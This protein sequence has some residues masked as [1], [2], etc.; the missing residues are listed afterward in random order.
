MPNRTDLEVALVNAKRSFRLCQLDVR[1]PQFFG[2]S[3][4][5][6]NNAAGFHFGAAVYSTACNLRIV[7]LA[8][9]GQTDAVS[10]RRQLAAVTATS[11]AAGFARR[12]WITPRN[13][14]SFGHGAGRGL[15]RRTRVR[16]VG[17][18]RD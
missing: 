15:G 13:P 6:W 2:K 14:A 10:V 1:L 8:E 16:F 17:A 11:E 5:S 3:L 12:L 7:E 9:D 18:C 4:T